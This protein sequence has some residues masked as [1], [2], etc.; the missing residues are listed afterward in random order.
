M[1]SLLAALLCAVW[2]G[3]SAQYDTARYTFTLE[4]DGLRIGAKEIQVQR[5]P[6]HANHLL[7]FPASGPDTRFELY[8]QDSTCVADTACALRVDMPADGETSTWVDIT[9]LASGRY[10]GYL[11][12][13]E[14]QSVFYLVFV[15]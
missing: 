6:D 8:R 4:M 12:W 1:R 5:D 15:R 11:K 7:Q 10:T 14:Q 13:G 3:A 2:S 9:K